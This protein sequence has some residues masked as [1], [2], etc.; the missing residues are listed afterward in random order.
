M[1]D[2]LLKKYK[3]EALANGL[4]FIK[5]LA[6]SPSNLYKINS[7][8]HIQE[9]KPYYVKSG[10][11]R[12]ST[13]LDLKIKKEASDNGLEIVSKL[14][15]TRKNLYRFIA[16]K[17]THE[18]STGHVRSGELRCSTCLNIKIKKEAI[19]NGLTFIKDLTNTRKKL[20]RFISRK[21]THE[22]TS[23]EVR[24]GQFRCHTC[25]DIKI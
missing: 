12:C 7:C 16:C 13:C 14:P 18:L 19:D 9:M 11:F 10:R 21:H 23:A 24:S 17:H 8:E 5:E 25:L 4:T 1:K 20:Y 6:N 3:S 15:H 2:A 22:I